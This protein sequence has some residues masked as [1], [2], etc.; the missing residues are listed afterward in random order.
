ML[1]LFQSIDLLLKFTLLK[2]C[3]LELP[4][5]LSDFR[6]E[7]FSIIIFLSQNPRNL[8]LERLNLSARRSDYGSTSISLHVGVCRLRIKIVLELDSFDQV[9]HVN[10]I[11][12]L[13]NLS[14][15]VRI[16][17]LILLIR[18]QECLD[19]FDLFNRKRA[20]ECLIQLIRLKVSANELTEIQ[21]RQ[22][23][24]QLWDASLLSLATQIF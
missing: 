11:A 19:T 8:A 14:Y 13:I 4:L 16:D 6:A 20:L 18:L 22:D 23:L 15:F 17:S 24:H 10:E 5:Q 1:F 2:V 21:A 7:E 3:F 9:I 12:P